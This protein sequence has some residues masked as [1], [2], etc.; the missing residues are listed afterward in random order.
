MIDST[1]MPGTEAAEKRTIGVSKVG[2]GAPVPAKPPYTAPPNT[3]TP[4]GVSAIHVGALD[5]AENEIVEIYTKVSDQYAVY[6]ARDRK[7]TKTRV[8]I[9]Y[10]DDAGIAA[11]QRKRMAPLS[12][13]RSEITGL[14][15]NWSDSRFE[16]FREKSRSY[17]SRLAAAL[18]LCLEEEDPD[19]ALA[20]L[21]EISKDIVEDRTSWGRFE[22]LLAASAATI[23]SILLLQLIKTQA[24][25]ADTGSLWLAA[26]AGAVGAFFSVAIALRNRTVLPNSRRKDNVADASLRIVIGI[27]A[28]GVLILILRA[29]VMPNFKIGDAVLSGKAIAWQAVLVVGFLAGFLERLVPN[30]LSRAEGDRDGARG[31][32]GVGDGA[33]KDAGRGK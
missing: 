23:I 11:Q 21:N 1:D 28:A 7:T 33:A 5:A 27:I 19:G 17:E 31:A 2:A 9:Q 24:A 30:L 32:G 15:S 3:V 12:A 20:S 10:A 6:L 4:P 29:D 16:T 13:K 26:R 14:L 25:S 22:Y 8:V 18:I